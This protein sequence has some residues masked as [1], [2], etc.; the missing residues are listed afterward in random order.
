MTSLF[1]FLAALGPMLTVVALR[2]VLAEGHGIDAFGMHIFVAL[3]MLGAAI[4]APVLGR[5][6]DR[7]GRVRVLA[8]SLA[9]VDAV[10]AIAT[11]LPSPTSLVFALRPVHGAASM[12]LLALLFASVRAAPAGMIVRAGVPM[13][14]ALALGP[15]LGGVLAK[16]SARGPFVA[17]AIL[18]SLLAVALLARSA[19]MGAHSQRRATRFRD[20]LTPLAAPLALT[21][22]HRFAIGGLVVAFATRARLVHGMA[23]HT[24]GACFSVLLVVFAIAICPVARV[25][26]PKVRAWTMALGTVL[27]AASIAS[28]SAAP[29]WGLVVSLALAGVGSAMIYA[30]TLA[31]AQRASITGERATAMGLVHAAGALGMIAGPLVAALLD[32]AMHTQPTEVRAAAFMTLSGALVAALGLGLTPKLLAIASMARSA[33]QSTITTPIA[34]KYR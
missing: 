29:R 16:H 7:S 17:A 1:V 32:R 4:G 3:G 22:A 6:A 30:P 11:A 33:H 26:E 10:T 34:P 14:T 15:A 20:L 8:A 27:F 23:D 18:S 13:V 24:I 21:A 2:R 25:E 31:L 19:P 9:L 5:I 12:G 28:L